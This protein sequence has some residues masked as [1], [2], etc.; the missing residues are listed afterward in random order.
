MKNNLKVLVN[1]NPVN[2]AMPNQIPLTGLL[3]LIQF[4][5]NLAQLPIGSISVN[6]KPATQHLNRENL[7]NTGF[8]R[9]NITEY[10]AKK[11]RASRTYR[12]LLVILL[13]ALICPIPLHHLVQPNQTL[14]S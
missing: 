4:V 6:K 13:F 3:T 14:L 2:G 8:K 12:S 9:R 10:E 5:T 11:N 7:V 1:R